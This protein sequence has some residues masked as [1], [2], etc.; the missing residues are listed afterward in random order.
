MAD[1]NPTL[2]SV[3][4]F[5]TVVDVTDLNDGTRRLGELVAKYG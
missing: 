1:T 3:M 4:V 2:N 5:N